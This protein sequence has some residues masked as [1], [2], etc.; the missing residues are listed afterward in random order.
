MHT[1][2]LLSLCFFKLG[3]L[4]D[5][6]RTWTKETP[7][8]FL[9]F[10]LLL[11]LDAL[12]TAKVRT[13]I[14]MHTTEK[15]RNWQNEGSSVGTFLSCL[16]GKSSPFDLSPIQCNQRC[17]I[18]SFMIS[19]NSIPLSIFDCMY[20]YLPPPPW[21]NLNPSH[22]TCIHIFLFPILY[23]SPKP[24]QKV[25]KKYLITCLMMHSMYKYNNY[26]WQSP[27]KWKQKTSLS[28]LM[29]PTSFHFQRL[30][31]KFSHQ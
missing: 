15:A 27:S 30:W 7:N 11:M 25:I 24:L 13:P 18:H 1:L 22:S 20:S 26:C 19:F 8:S 16:P 9:C 17:K 23:P 6:E 28:C 31:E 5:K 4:N 2:V 21:S 10:S 12:L 3:L 29:S 14:W